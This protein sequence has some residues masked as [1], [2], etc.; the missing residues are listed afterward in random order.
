M[1][2]TIIYRPPFQ[3]GYFTLSEMSFSIIQPHAFPRNYHVK[4][5]S[6][7][8]PSLAGSQWCFWNLW[9]WVH[10][11]FLRLRQRVRRPLLNCKIICEF[12]NFIWELEVLLKSTSLF[13]ND[14]LNFRKTLHNRLY[15]TLGHRLHFRRKHVFGIF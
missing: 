12:I 2:H 1:N 6:T 7:P 5:L 10:T 4:S 3:K 15:G 8:S 14:N 11:C 13:W 9:F